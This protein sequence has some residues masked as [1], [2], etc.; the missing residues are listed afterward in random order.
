MQMTILESCRR[1]AKST[2]RHF[3]RFAFVRGSREHTIAIWTASIAVTALW[4]GYETKTK[5]SNK[6]E[7]FGS[8]E[9]AKWNSLK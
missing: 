2:A 3:G 9:I 7:I 1:Y 4:I 6:A 5:K 8:D